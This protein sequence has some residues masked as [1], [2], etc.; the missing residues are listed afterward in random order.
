LLGERRQKALQSNEAWSDPVELIP[1]NLNDIQSD[2][3]DKEVFKP[4]LGKKF[5]W[6]LDH[7]RAL[8][9]NAVAHLDPARRVLDADKFEDLGACEDAIPVL[10]YIARKML[11]REL[12]ARRPDSQDQVGDAATE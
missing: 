9:R 10:K 11:D 12:Q 6:V 5:N 2:G 3:W 4:F 8:I 7:Y 1:D